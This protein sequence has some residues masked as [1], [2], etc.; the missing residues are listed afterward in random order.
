ME[1]SGANV[2]VQFKNNKRFVFLT[3]SSFHPQSAKMERFYLCTYICTFN[4]WS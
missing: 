2:T 3:F 1:V 4:T